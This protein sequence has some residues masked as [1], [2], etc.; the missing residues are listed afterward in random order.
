MSKIAQTFSKLKEEGKKALIPYISCGDPNL[1]FTKELVLKMAQ[2]GADLI[3]LGIPYSDP[4]A[5]G[6]TIQKAS[7]R[8]LEAGITLEAIFQL[9][10]QLRQETDIPLLFM[11][12]YNTIYKTGLEKF[13]LRAALVGIDGLIV[14][15]LPLEEAKPLKEMTD[16]Y[17]LDLIFLVAPTST[18]TR[19]EK[20]AQLARGFIYCVSVT[21]VTGSRQVVASDLQDFLQRVRLRTSLPLAVGFGISSPETAREVVSLADGAIVGS[22]VI[23]RIE[24][25]LS[26]IEKQP[27]IVIK[28]VCDYL[29]SLKEAMK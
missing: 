21:G 28:E 3:E 11:T 6:L 27:E 5:D 4:V 9:V 20:I 10:S 12:Y 22:S 14:P 13:V 1:N 17:N 16:K 23:E 18:D 15:D 26:C 29:Q 19:I 2:N 7:L 24:K 8:A 25:N